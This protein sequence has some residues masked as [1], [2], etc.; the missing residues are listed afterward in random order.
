MGGCVDGWAGVSMG[1]RGY[2]R[3]APSLAERYSHVLIHPSTHPPIPPST[4]PPIPPSPHPPIPPSTHPPIHPSTL[5]VLPRRK[6][7]RRRDL[8]AG[9]R[10]QRRRTVDVVE[11]H[12]FIRRVHV[13]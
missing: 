7:R 3:K 6:I 5:R 8:A 9:F 1:G 11:T 13:A 2:K 10:D 12:H 4:H